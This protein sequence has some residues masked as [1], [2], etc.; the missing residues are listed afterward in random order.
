MYTPG[1]SIDDPTDK[2]ITIRMRQETFEHIRRLAQSEKRSI[3]K[4]IEWLI[5]KAAAETPTPLRPEPP[6]TADPKTEPANAP[7]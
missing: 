3:T 6:S 1:M 2:A 4:Q 5:E 7:A